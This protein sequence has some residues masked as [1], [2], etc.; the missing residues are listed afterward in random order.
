ML[1]RISPFRNQNSKNNSSPTKYIKAQAVFDNGV[2]TFSNASYT[3]TTNS[4]LRK[5]ISFAQIPRF[6]DYNYHSK[7]AAG[8]NKLFPDLK[9]KVTDLQSIVGAHELQRVLKRANADNFSVGGEEL[10]NVKNGRFRVNLHS[11]TTDSDGRFSVEELLNSVAEYANKINK[12]VYI[13]ITNHD[14]INGL[15]EALRLAVL[16]KEK[17]KNV[18]IVLGVEF[19]AKHEDPKVFRKPLQFEMIGYCINPFDDNLNSFF[20]QMKTGNSNYADKIIEKVNLHYGTQ[21]EFNQLQDYDSSLINGG[22]PSFLSKLKEVLSAKVEETGQ[23]AEYLEGLFKAH[24]EKYGDLKLTDATYS[25]KDI[26][27]VTQGASGVVGIAHPVRNRLGRKINLPTRAER[28]AVHDKVLYDFFKEFKQLGGK[29]LEA[30]YQYK[31]KH[32]SRPSQVKK[33]E[34]IRQVCKDL[35]LLS[36]S[37]LDN[38][39]RDLFH[40]N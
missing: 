1:T 7:L 34:F 2:D 14:T 30:D 28:E 27:S 29:I 32:I 23:N 13:G 25:M 16:N 21:I 39:G 3:K 37:G 4:E 38:H 18:K 8:I 10:T 33:R 20:H 17:F 24:S 22:S 35:D 26:T 9:C 11:H 5:E 19:N 36:S 40:S 12:P 31:P 15:T 6:R